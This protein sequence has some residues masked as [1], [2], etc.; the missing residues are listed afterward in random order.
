MISTDWHL[1]L[2]FP[3]IKSIALLTLPLCTVSIFLFIVSL[4]TVWQLL[5]LGYIPE[6]PANDLA[7]HIASILNFKDAFLDGQ[8]LPRLQL[9]PS[10]IPDLP[11]F[12]FY[13][14]LTGFLSLPFLI[15]D[16]KPLVALT[17]AIL[18]VRWVG[19]LAIFKTGRLLGANA[20]ASSLAAVSYLLTPYIISNF[21]GRVA[22]P[23]STAH[24]VMP[25]LLYGII[26]LY[27]TSDIAGVII[28]S[29]TLVAL[30]LAHPIFLLF[31]C[32]VASLFA[33][34]LLRARFLSIAG[35]VLIC[36]ILLASFQWIPGFVYRND[37]VSNFTAYSP[38]EQRQ[39]T[40][41]SG[42]IGPAHSLVDDGLCS[43]QSRLYLTPGILTIPIL[44]MLA[45]RL[46]KPIER[47]TFGCLLLMLFASYSPFDFWRFIPSFFWSVQFPYRLLSFV[48][49]LTSLGLCLSL[50]NLRSYQWALLTIVILAQSSVILFQKP[51]SIPL[52]IGMDSSTLKQSFAS[53]DYTFR[54]APL[55]LVSNDHWLLHYS[56]PLYSMEYNNPLIV[57]QQGILLKHN[58]IVVGITKT[59]QNFIR[60]SGSM[61]NAK[62]SCAHT[63]WLAY[64]SSPLSPL[65]G[66]RDVDLDEFSLIF[67]LPNDGR[68]LTLQCKASMHSPQIHGMQNYCPDIY[69]TAIE[70]LPA[71][72][73]VVTETSS[74]VTI[75][76]IDGDSI[77]TDAPVDLWIAR[78]SSPDLPLTGKIS[79]GPGAFS[80]S[81]TLPQEEGEYILVASRYVVPALETHGSSDYR[82]LSVSIRAISKVVE[83]ED[84]PIT[85]PSTSISRIKATGYHRIFKLKSAQYLSDLPDRPSIIVE[86]PMA[87]SPMIE[88]TQN[89]VQLLSSP[90]NLGLIS[91]R[92]HDLR[93]PFVA[94]FRWPTMAL[95]GTIAG[96]IA[97]LFIILKMAK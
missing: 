74:K 29:L 48:A 97:M 47:T 2:K 1:Q 13:G 14:S 63:I 3:N 30:S 17:L 94:R 56:T 24:G 55:M 58:A 50:K 73:F 5:T 53:Q 6:T 61:R 72:G 25:F 9:V 57:D 71:N 95:L 8:Y 19:A 49:L 79:V 11:F 41:P 70:Y 80:S 90:T 23:E 37:F 27:I 32:L 91:V 60:V 69:L 15:L 81:M 35:C 34:F 87:F 75:L 88:V 83:G 93:S 77:F 62:T 4:L 45:F 16:F 96:G 51:Y 40:S 54:Q 26:R 66:M 39:W 89:D 82:R 44:I 28:T 59:S 12:Q 7:K 33:L 38:F 78:A 67:E 10:S 92:T 22:V 65:D 31:G 42:L 84:A 68:A 52:S 21:Y 43:I 76:Y 46:N 36:G 20:W 86:L 85:V 64:A 18:T